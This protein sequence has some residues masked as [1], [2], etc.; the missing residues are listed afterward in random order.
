MRKVF[1]D[2]L[3]RWEIGEGVGKAGTINW[4]KSVGHKVKFT[5]DDI[6]GDIS[7]INHQKVGK[8]CFLTVKYLNNETFEISPSNFYCG[9]LGGILG[10][11]TNKYKKNIGDIVCGKFSKIKIIKQTK[12]HKRKYYEYEC[13]VCGNIDTIS[14]SNLKANKGCNVCCVPST[15]ILK[16]YND[17]ATTHPDLIKYFKNIKDAYKYSY[18]STQ[19][20]YF[21][22]P[23]CKN[24]RYMSVEC[25]YSNNFNCPKCGDKTSYPEKVLFNILEQ[26]QLKFTYQLTHTVLN[27]CNN[28]KYDFY[29]EYNGE[30]Y[31]IETHGL[32]HYSR[33]F[34]TCGGQTVLEVQE[35]DKTKKEL[36]LSN[37]IKEENYIVIDCRKSNLEFIKRNILNSKLGELFDMSNI[38]WASVEEFALSSRVKEA[39]DL[40]NDGIDSTRKIG[41]LMKLSY[42][43]II[44]YLTKGEYIGW[45]TY[46]GREELIK[47]AKKQGKNGKLV[48]IFKGDKSLGVFKSCAELSRQSEELFD[49]KFNLNGIVRVCNKE[50]SHHKG[51][52]FRYI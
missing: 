29:F 31:I 10:I 3:P 23:V 26:L 46:N 51:Y 24:T 40:W 43:T 39:C 50:R 33:S 36:A 37:G 8:K 30:S 34:E 19:N 1:L 7:I 18:N 42:P 13:M 35:N 32:Q 49:I 22:C 11:K 21:I 38:N 5:Y 16:G 47:G 44:R 6:N 48:E 9:I 20:C 4:K 17:I 41:R 27:W 14:E 12:K 2:D 45:T 25:L 15:K 28:Y 52:I